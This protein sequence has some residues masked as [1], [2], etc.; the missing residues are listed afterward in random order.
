M[1]NKINLLKALAILIVVSGHLEFSLIPMFPPYS[2]QVMV[3][4][5]IAGMLYKEKYTF[6]EYFKK[7]FK[8]LMVPYFLYAGFYLIL[9]LALAPVTGKFWGMPVTFK[10]ELLMPFLTGHQIDLIS[11]LW[12]VPSLFITLLIYKLLSYIKCPDNVRLAL[13]LILSLLSIQMQDYASNLNVLW[14]LRSAFSMFFIHLGYVYKNKIEGKYNIFSWKIFSAVIILQS[15]LWLTNKDFS[16][17]D[18]IGLHFLVVWG[19]YNNPVVPVLTSLTGIWISLFIVEILYEKIKNF[20][21]IQ[22]IGQNTYHIMANHLLV[23]NILTYTALFLKGIPFDI[24]NNADIYWFYFPLKTTYFYF[25]AG[26]ILTTYLG[27]FLKFLNRSLTGRIGKIFHN[28]EK[29][30]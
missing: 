25:I 14:L 7:R 23:F 4:F 1:D 12:F 24:K 3:F 27:V 11:P 20:G 8:S 10:N 30:S 26:I 28:T 16:P 9:T 21:F 5:F 13:Y 19:E 29:I 6:I 15:V 18:G 2:F 22:K 17:M